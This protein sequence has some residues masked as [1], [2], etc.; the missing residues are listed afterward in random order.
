MNEVIEINELLKKMKYKFIPH[1]ADI[2]YL[3]FGKTLEE[4]FENS[5]YA[6][7]NVICKQKIMKKVKKKF[8][9]IGRD[10]E[11]LLYNFL[12]EILYFFEVGGFLISEFRNMKIVGFP[13]VKGNKKFYNLELICDVIGDDVDNYKI[14]MQVKAATYHE[15]Y[16][17][18]K[19]TK[20][21]KS[22]MCQVVLDV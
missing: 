20:K 16:I 21:G 1:T 3:A 13:I 18:E 7:I 15:M 8:K 19:L 4:C 11:N 10:R 6:L 17:Q 2:K 12:E 14:D 22:L 5:G 9:V